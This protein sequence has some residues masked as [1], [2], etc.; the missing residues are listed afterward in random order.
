MFY[1]TLQNKPHKV[2]DFL[3]RKGYNSDD[4]FK[5]MD[6]LLDIIKE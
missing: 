3:M 4:I 1:N 2:F 5:H 6:E